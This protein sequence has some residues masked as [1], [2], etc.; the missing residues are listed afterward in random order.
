MQRAAHA[1]PY[2]GILF[3]PNEYIFSILRS[4][5][6]HRHDTEATLTNTFAML[7]KKCCTFQKERW[8]ADG[9]LLHIY[10]CTAVT[11]F[12]GGSLHQPVYDLYQGLEF[13]FQRGLRIES[14]IL[15]ETSLRCQCPKL[16]I[17]DVQCSISLAGKNIV[18]DTKFLMVFLIP[19]AKRSILNSSCSGR[20]CCQGNIGRKNSPRTMAKTSDQFIRRFL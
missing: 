16:K 12:N 4:R 3:I 14:V 18:T 5:H 17:G 1:D 15:S 7:I 19:Q 8:T 11:T 6:N 9:L 20:G 10:I 2:V 13:V